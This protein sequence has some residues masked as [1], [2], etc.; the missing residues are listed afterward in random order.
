MIVP[1]LQLGIRGV[2]RVLGDHP[3]P[4]EVVPHGYVRSDEHLRITSYNVCYTKLLRVVAAYVW[5]YQEGMEFLR[6]FWDAAIAVDP[7]AERLDEG[8]RFPLCRPASLS[9]L[10]AQAGLQEVTVGPLEVTT[11]FANFRNNFV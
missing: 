1:L 9:D 11:S 3:R 10:F 4:N 5:D 8:R 2:P 7:A 6:L